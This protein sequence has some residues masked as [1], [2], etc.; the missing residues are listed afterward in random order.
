MSAR[1]FELFQ[2]G[3]GCGRI[4][5]GGD[6]EDAQAAGGAARNV[7]GQANP[8]RDIIDFLID[9]AALLQLLVQ[10]VALA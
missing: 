2:D 6:F 5:D 8:F 7:A 10:R 9:H 3:L 4:V 1:R